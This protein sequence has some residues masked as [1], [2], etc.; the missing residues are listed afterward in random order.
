[1]CVAKDAN[2]RLFLVQKNPSF[3]RQ[4]PAFVQNMTDRDAAACQFDH[5]LRRKY[6]KFTCIDVAGHG[7]DWRDLFQLL[8]D[9][10]LANVPCVEN[11]IDVSEVPPNGRIEQAMGIGNH[12]D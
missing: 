11:V 2:V 3:F 8:D 4:L 7:G 10:P 9:G 5:S 1:M 6:A 12:S